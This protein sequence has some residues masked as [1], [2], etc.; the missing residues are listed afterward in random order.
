MKKVIRLT[1]L[2]LTRIVKRV[3]NETKSNKVIT[4]GIAGLTA[5]G[6]IFYVNDLND[7]DVIDKNGNSYEAESGDSFR[8]KIIDMEGSG[9][10]GGETSITIK[11][12]DGK[13]VSFRTSKRVY[14]LKP[15]DTITVKVSEDT[16]LFT[17]RGQIE[18]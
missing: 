18:R 3:I 9:P 7:V 8:G 15:G 14:N 10:R 12:K 16:W 17:D 6:L 5:A 1:E 13:E 11:T 2:D 4:A